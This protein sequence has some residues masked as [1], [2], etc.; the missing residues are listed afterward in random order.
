VS[1]KNTLKPTLLLFLSITYS[2][3]STAV[4]DQE[5]KALQ[6]RLN[7]LAD[8]I[9]QNASANSDTTI[10][11]YGELHYNN[12]S[13]GSKSQ[14]KEL[15]FHRFVLFFGHEFSSKVRMFSE[16]ELEHALVADNNECSFTV[17]AMGLNAGDTVSCSGSSSPG[18][19]ELEQAYVQID[20]DGNKTFNAGVFLIPVG[21]MNET[22]EPATFYG[23]ERNPVEKNII[24]ATWWEAGVMLSGNT[25]NAFSYDIA[26]TS[27]L[28]GGTNI[29][30]GRQKVAQADASN[31]ALTGRL[32]Y[33]GI[34]GLELA[35]T[36]QIQDDMTQDSSD[37][38]DGATLIETHVIWNQAAT[39]IKALYA[40]W[41]I[42]S[43]FSDLQQGG[44]VEASYKLQPETGI[45]VRHNIWNNGGSEKTQTDIGLNY[46]LHEDVVFK[47]DLQLQD[48]NAGNSDG[49]N[50]GVGYQF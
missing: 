15:D 40:R 7:Q 11:G 48:D 27:G 14:K 10:A 21:I 8:S 28:D 23:T 50:A 18:E 45:F 3:V 22:H 4:T 38:I 34:A 43:A 39:T 17:P 32:K 29:R 46:W 31:L 5:F 19:V 37:A 42:D 49:F 33:T 30:G 25:E 9:E 24:P 35:G 6:D 26:L 44:Y 36:L 20:L 47:I 12:L 16:F 2:S 1:I 13:N 41:D